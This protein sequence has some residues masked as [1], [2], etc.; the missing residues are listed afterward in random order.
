MLRKIKLHGD[1]AEFLGQD[2]F[3]AVVKTTAEAVKF[4]IMQQ[5]KFVLA[6]Y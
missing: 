2:E 6:Y 4:L 5:R 1:L 3:E